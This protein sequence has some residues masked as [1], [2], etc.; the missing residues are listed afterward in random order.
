MRVTY[1]ENFRKDTYI[2]SALLSLLSH[3]SYPP[4]YRRVLSFFSEYSRSFGA[5]AGDCTPAFAPSGPLCSMLGLQ[6]KERGLSAW[7][8]MIASQSRTMHGLILG[9]CNAGN[10]T[11][12]AVVCCN[13]KMFSRD[14]LSQSWARLA[15]RVGPPRHL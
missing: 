10:S 11:N 13:A 12:S 8:R 15:D 6:P 14:F 4:Y 5:V 3:V 9:S 2:F 1:G 7:V